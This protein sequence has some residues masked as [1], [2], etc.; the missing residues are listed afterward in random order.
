MLLSF[1]ETLGTLKNIA[2]RPPHLSALPL[3]SYE[4]WINR[5]MWREKVRLARIALQHGIFH[6]QNMR[7]DKGITDIAAAGAIYHKEITRAMK[8]AQTA[9]P[10]SFVPPEWFKVTVKILI[11]KGVV[12]E[13]IT[14]C[15]CSEP[16]V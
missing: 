14:P 9:D 6:V 7:L 16:P 3:H 8:V 10:E 4:F 11:F 5:L 12:V 1:S 2:F 15:T 13:S